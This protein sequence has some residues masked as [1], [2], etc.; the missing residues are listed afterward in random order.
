MTKE[1]EPTPLAGGGRTAVSRHGKVVIRETGPW[2]RSVHSLLLHLQEVGFAGA[3]RVVGDGF[4]GQGREI[5]PYI[6]GDVINPA[7][8]TDDAIHE[9]GRLIWRLHDATASFR[10]P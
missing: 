4:D 9:L 8:W 6:E 2:A 3:P 5:L 1:D 10:P 7:P